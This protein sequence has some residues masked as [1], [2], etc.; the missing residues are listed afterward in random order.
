MSEPVGAIF[1]DAVGTLIRPEPNVAAV[2][3]EAGKRHGSAL[4][5]DEIR[6]RFFRE[7]ARH[8]RLDEMRCWKTSEDNEVHRWRQIVKRVFPDVRDT[9][10]CFRELWDHFAR[11]ESWRLTDGA[12][13]VLC[14]LLRRGWVLGLASNFD[15]RLR[16]IVDG[17]PDLW[18]L[19]HI[20]ISSEVG[21]LKPAPQFFEQVKSC[22]QVPSEKILFV[23]DDR[24]N[25]YAGAEA[26]GLT[27]VLYDPSDREP[28]F[29]GFRIPHL[30]ELL[31]SCD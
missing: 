21:W 26:A 5:T 12:G 14:E 11:P 10:A 2:Y 17:F 8:V 25:D 7:F 27:P 20:V 13:E 24:R 30:R 28:A 16:G 4:C 22:V 9:E 23:G 18:T 1:F 15:S 6:D 31:L 19:T 29:R 3:T